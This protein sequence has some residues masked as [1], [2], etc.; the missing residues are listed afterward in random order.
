[1]K[2]AVITGITGQDGA[3]LS[4]LLLDKGYKV[5]G[6]SPRRSS[7]N[8]WRLRELDVEDKVELLPVDV[9]DLA[10]VIEGVRYAQ[11]SEVYNLAAQSFV[12][13]SFTAPASTFA[14]NATGAINMLEAVRKEVPH[15]RFY[16]ASTSE[17]FGLT[18]VEGQNENTRFHPRSPYG[19]AKV[20]AHFAVRN[21]HEAYGLHASCGILFNHESPLR[22][23]EFVTR[24]ISKGIASIVTGKQKVLSLGNLD[25]MRDWGHAKDYVYGMWLMLQK[26][27]PSDYVLATGESHSIKE[28]LTKAFSAVDMNWEDYVVFDPKYTRPSD[29]PFL[30]GDSTKA[31][32]ELGW[33]PKCSFNDLVHEM[34][35]TDLNRQG[36]FDTNK[37][38]GGRKNV[39]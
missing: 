11:P 37:D 4:K 30:L 7:D 21:Y 8:L 14:I 17:M 34:V 23:E 28:F 2:S 24:K 16:Q 29:V 3:Y 33:R 20:A 6:F 9:T 35:F 25:A 31:Q 19:V 39:S 22:G 13:A 1:M 36:F 38:L 32:T 15:A 26:E 27:S 5:F 18:D 10:S 12:A